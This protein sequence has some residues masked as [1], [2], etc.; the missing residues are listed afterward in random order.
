MDESS[1]TDW[2]FH[3]HYVHLETKLFEKKLRE[4]GRLEESASQGKGLQQNQLDKIMRKQE[5]SNEL[6]CLSSCSTSLMEVWENYPDMFLRVLALIPST[7][8]L[9]MALTCRQLLPVVLQHHWNAVSSEAPSST[10]CMWRARQA[11]TM[12]LMRN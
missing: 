1:L 2:I 4:I 3:R 9:S 8:S 12:R 5:Y 10:L 6:R 7:S 11:L